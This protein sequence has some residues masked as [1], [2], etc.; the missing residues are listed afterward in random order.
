MNFELTLEQKE[1]KIRFRKFVDK[2]VVPNAATYDRLEETPLEL[3]KA[4]ANEGYLSALI[5][6]K[7]FAKAAESNNRDD[8]GENIDDDSCANISKEMDSLTWGLLCEEI[9]HASGSLVSLLTVH[10]MVIQA[11]LKWG[12]EAQRSHWLPLLATGEVIG[13][14]GLTEVKTGSD[15][16]NAQT[17]AVQDG[18]SYIINGQKKWISFGQVARLFLILAQV[19]GKATAFLIERER[20]GFSTEPIK[21]MLGFR[22]AMLATLNMNNC[23]IPASNMVGKIGFGF[24]HVAGTALDQGRYCIAWGCLGLAQGCVD[25]SLAYS[26][27]RKQ[28]GVSLKEHQLIQ[29]LIADMITQ[30][31]ASRMLCY[32]AAFLKENKDPSLIMETSMAKYFASRTA[33]KVASD[34]VQIHGANG[35]S[36]SY[37][38]ERHFRDAKIMEIIEGSNQMQQIIIS[39]YGYQ[40]YLSSQ[41]K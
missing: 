27:E 24:S 30:T 16:K 25:A 7:Y 17:T 14:F 8:R 21:G 37:P 20:E 26:T 4:M 6:S 15:A 35:C 1:A 9:G 31:Q 29:E 28:F 36:D 39:R 33:L 32:N 10:S 12:T 2:Y 3:I 11:L 22:S 34:A 5:P 41:S 19:D 18:D 23:R 38:V 13:G 40:R